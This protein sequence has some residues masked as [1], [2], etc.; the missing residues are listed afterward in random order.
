M[1]THGVAATSQPLAVLTGMQIMQ[2]G[3]NAVDAAVA[4]AAM[5]NV[6]EPMSTGIGGDVFALI[7][8]AKSGTTMG[9]N[10]SGRS[11]GSA[12]LKEYQ[13][14]LA[15]LGKND[16]PPHS[17]L[18]WTVPGA[19]DGWA[20][21]I[22]KWGRMA[23][24]QVLA[25]AIRAA[26]DGIAVAPQT[27]AAWEQ[28]AEILLQH[29]D[30]AKT[31][32]FPDGHAPRAGE[33]FRNP[34]LGRTLRM[35]AEGGRDVFYRGNIADA[36]VRFSEQNGGLFTHS[37]L[38]NHTSNLLEPICTECRGYEVLGFPPNS[39][40]VATLEALSILEGKGIGAMGH[41]SPDTIHLQLEAMKLAL[42]DAWCHVTD[43]DFCKVPAE[44]LL[45]PE[46]VRKQSGCISMERAIQQS[47][48][49]SSAGDT[50]YICAADGE[51][52]VASFMNSVFM[53]WGSGLTVE[54]TGILLQ[55]RG[56]CFSLDPASV[57]LIAPGKRTRHTLSPAMVLHQGRPFVAFGFVGGDMQVQAQVQFL[58]NVIDFGMNVQDALD[59]PRW[60]YNGTD[61][62]IAVESGISSETQAELIKRGHQVTGSDGF[63][64]AGQA[65]LI[66]R[67]LGSFQ[68]GSDGRRDGCALGY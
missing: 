60:R 29:A 34:S 51:G 5:L 67:Q 27:A 30:S 62:S 38:A 8:E 66:H 16:I 55:N 53:P 9:V 43:L 61:S 32:L 11:P 40:G 52:N 44:S 31:W 19:L 17:P 14:R 41:N 33:V 24:A 64:G 56:H 22:Q 2:Q 37:D 6:V 10:A 13:N 46:Y 49:S 7:Y 15:R 45:E 3:G 48:C 18:A 12:S 4:M 54:D 20:T 68:A 50:V 1:G 21:V 59:A 25:P 58:S 65:I 57:N 35:I 63:F 26:E 47:D 36:I 42:H 39:Q 28:G 23:L